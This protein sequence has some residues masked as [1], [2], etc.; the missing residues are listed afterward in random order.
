MKPPSG[1]F[2]LRDKD[3]ILIPHDSSYKTSKIRFSWDVSDFV[4]GHNG[5]MLC[6]MGTCILV[7]VD[8]IPPIWSAFSYTFVAHKVDSDNPAPRDT[9]AYCGPIGPNKRSAKYIKWT[10]QD[11]RNAVKTYFHYMDNTAPRVLYCHSVSNAEH[12]AAKRIST[13]YQHDPKRNQQPFQTWAVH[14]CFPR[15]G[16]CLFKKV[17]GARHWLFQSKFRPL[18][19]HVHHELAWCNQ[20]AN[21]HQLPWEACVYQQDVIS[22]ILFVSN[23]WLP[24]Q[25]QT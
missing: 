6:V 1:W 9:N 17:C 21:K 15:R 5:D 3:N 2:S 11:M 25:Q 22:R 24:Y 19:S 10:T 14:T 18:T 13:R 7:R 4:P 23:R 20:E 12:T 16:V 8:E